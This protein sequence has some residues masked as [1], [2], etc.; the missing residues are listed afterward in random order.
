[1]HHTVNSLYRLNSYQ[2]AAIAGAEVETIRYPCG[3]QNESLQIYIDD[4][5]S[6]GIFRI[7][8]DYRTDKFTEQEIERL[9][10]HICSVLD[11][12]LTDDTKKISELNL[13][14]EEERNLLLYQFNDTDT[15]FEINVSTNCLRN[16]QRKH[17]IKMQ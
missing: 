1:M 11:D 4:R 5:D 17:R 3:S 7:H 10:Q 16:R 13:L 9:H 2:N 15:L 8:Y 6:E 12:A 14:T